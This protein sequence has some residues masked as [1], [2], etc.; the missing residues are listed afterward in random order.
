MVVVN[1]DGPETLDQIALD[2]AIMKEA[3][4]CKLV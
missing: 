3:N 1:V 2:L 4:V